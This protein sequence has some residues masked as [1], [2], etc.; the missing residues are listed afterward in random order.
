MLY[1]VKTPKWLKIL[2]PNRI[3]EMDV[4]K[5]EIYLTFDDGPHNTITSFVLNELK[6]Y[7]ALATFFCIG[8]NV[9]N[10]PAVYQRII[11][12]GHAVGNHTQ[13]HLNGYQKL[14][15]VYVDDILEASK[16]IDSNLFRPPYGR[17]KPYQA[18]IITTLK[19]PYKI[20]MWTLL[21]GDFDTTLSPERCFENVVFKIS[22]GSI[23]VFH[24]SEK[25]AERMMFALPKVLKTFSDKGYVF[26]KLA[27][28]KINNKAV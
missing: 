6:K 14:D 9:I 16:S 22:N 5:K 10:N 19:N 17:I 7:N 12:E 1:F 26:K 23:V 3:W 25:A 2:Y 28:T 21:S 20:I 8:N 18:K 15:K 24:D 27:V 4:H 13:Q 11:D